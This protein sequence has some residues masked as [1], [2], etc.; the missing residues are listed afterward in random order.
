MKIKYLLIIIFTIF[1]FY[2]TDKV[3]ELSE[4]NNT[5]LASI[6]DYASI[7]DNECIEGQINNEGI[8]LGLNGISVDKNK[9]YSNMKG[10]GFNKDLLEYKKNKCIL[11]KEDNLD[12]YILSGNTHENNISLVIDMNDFNYYKDLEIISNREKIE[13]NYLV[14]IN[15]YRADLKNIL[16]K[17]NTDNIKKFK[18]LFN[19]FYCV[20]TNDFDILSYCKKEKI[21]TIKIVNYI[22]KDL[23][24]NTKKILNKGIIIFIKENYQ[25]TS[26]LSSTINYIKSRGYNIVSIDKLLS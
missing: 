18:K 4:Y 8:I 2:Y 14:N 12:K 19:N 15:N 3:I 7:Y 1:S 9:S 13:L 23:L 5:I 21:N 26:E 17:T 22:D 25:N 16:F 10:I 6:N 24:L 20:K 11:N